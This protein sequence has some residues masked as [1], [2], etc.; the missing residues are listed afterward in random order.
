MVVWQPLP[1]V[2]KLDY[3]M[4]RDSS[5]IV[6]YCAGLSGVQARYS[7]ACARLTFSLADTLMC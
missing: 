1:V 5:G 7:R 4:P 2:G 6:L 3:T